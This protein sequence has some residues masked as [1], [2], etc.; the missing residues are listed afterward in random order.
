MIMS[1]LA[2]IDYK[3]NIYLVSYLYYIRIFVFDVLPIV[4]QAVT[5]VDINYP[6]FSH[7]K[8]LNMCHILSIVQNIAS[9]TYILTVCAKTFV[10]E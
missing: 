8:Q 7:I 3:S 10:S 2:S 5:S 6:P 9:L 4:L 1:E